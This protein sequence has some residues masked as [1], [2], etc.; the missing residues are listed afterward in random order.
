M[1][2]I[3]AALKQDVIWGQAN[4]CYHGLSSM[5]FLFFPNARNPTQIHTRAAALA[6][7]I[8]KQQTATWRNDESLIRAL[9]NQAALL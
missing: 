8:C 7:Q 5:T 4:D 2:I 6:T 9:D 1:K 3:L